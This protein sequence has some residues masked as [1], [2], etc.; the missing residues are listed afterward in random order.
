MLKSL[1]T[2]WALLKEFAGMVRHRRDYILIPILLL[3]L[4]IFIFLLTAEAPV[5]I[6]FFYTVF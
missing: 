6:P 2:K 5:L 4:V 1:S 3:V